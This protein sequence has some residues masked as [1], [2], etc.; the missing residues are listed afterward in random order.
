M[1]ICE[2]LEAM[3]SQGQVG[4]SIEYNM[5]KNF[6]P[7]FFNVDICAKAVRQTSL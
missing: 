6:L 2:N 7:F 5:Q 3:H 4:M 1:L